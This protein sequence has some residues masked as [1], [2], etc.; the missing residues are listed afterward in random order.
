MIGI[1]DLVEKLGD[2]VFVGGRDSNELKHTTH[3]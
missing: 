3:F 2:G 1:N